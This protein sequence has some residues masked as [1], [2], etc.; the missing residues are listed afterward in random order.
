ML[1]RV[2]LFIE[3]NAYDD[4]MCAIILSALMVWWNTLSPLVVRICCSSMYTRT[5]TLYIALES[6]CNV[7]YHKI[8]ILNFV[9]EKL[10]FWVEIRSSSKAQM[11]EKTIILVNDMRR[12]GSKSETPKNMLIL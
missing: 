4:W 12:S 9:P 2:K 6:L 11:R 5:I 3:S 7:F 8:L 1:P 10:C